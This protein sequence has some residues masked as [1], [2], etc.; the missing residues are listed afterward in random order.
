MSSV[1][2]DKEETFIFQRGKPIAVIVDIER[3]N[4]L[5]ELE[6]IIEDLLIEEEIKRRM[7]NLN[8]KKFYS[9]EEVIKKLNLENE[10]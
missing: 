7:K 5:K 3:Y 10:L 8:N 9:F 2:F 6:E 1:V 4:K